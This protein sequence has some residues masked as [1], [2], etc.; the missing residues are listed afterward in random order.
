MK[1]V[2]VESWITTDRAKELFAA[3]GQVFDALKKAAVSKDFK[4]VA[5]NA[6]ANF[7]VKNTLRR[8]T[9]PMWLLKWKAQILLSRT[10][11]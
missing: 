1:R 10:N 8:S 9:P 7:E 4:P 6:K 2:A 5:L 11:T 3:S